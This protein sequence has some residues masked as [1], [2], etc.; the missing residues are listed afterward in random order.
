MY[1]CER[2]VC[3]RPVCVTGVRVC[4]STHVRERDSVSEHGLG[5][6]L[7]DLLRTSQGVLPFI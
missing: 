4:V 1:V 3:V 7:T 5:L 6:Q 2:P